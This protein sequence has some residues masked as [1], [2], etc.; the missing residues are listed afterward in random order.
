MK[1]KLVCVHK[2]TYLLSYPNS[3]LGCEGANVAVLQV[4]RRYLRDQLKALEIS[5]NFWLG[6]NHVQCY[7][8]SSN[9]TNNHLR[10]KLLA[11]IKFA[12]QWMQPIGL[13]CGK[14]W[15]VKLWLAFMVFKCLAFALSHETDCQCWHISIEI[16]VRSFIGLGL[17]NITAYWGIFLYS[18]MCLIDA[19]Y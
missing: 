14:F 19:I 18:N 17:K 2:W 13:V 9:K 7:S 11:N 12:D 3:F 6:Q 16:C 8:M 5:S 1:Y 15:G 4:N 10:D